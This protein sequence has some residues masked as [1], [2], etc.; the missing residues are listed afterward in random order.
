MKRAPI[1]SALALV[2][3]AAATLG[4][5]TPGTFDHSTNPYHRSQQKISWR[6]HD[7]AVYV[8]STL[9]LPICSNGRLLSTVLRKREK[10][11]L[12]T[13]LKSRIYHNLYY[14]RVRNSA[15]TLLGVY[16]YRFGWKMPL[17]LMSGRCVRPVHRTTIRVGY[18]LRT[19]MAVGWFHSTYPQ[20]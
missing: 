7:R 16:A 11:S 13:V 1:G 4:A 5:A 10:A 19:W 3:A 14:V 6:Q 9:N 18:R 15:H 17:G 12:F 2:V 8:V 20:S